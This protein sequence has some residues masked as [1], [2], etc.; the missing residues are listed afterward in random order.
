MNIDKLESD[1][2]SKNSLSKISRACRYY[3]FGKH[4]EPLKLLIKDLLDED[5]PNQI[6]CI[7]KFIEDHIHNSSYSSENQVYIHNDRNIKLMTVKEGIDSLILYVGLLKKRE[8]NL[9]KR[10]REK[11]ERRIQKKKEKKAIII[12]EKLKSFLLFQEIQIKF[13]VIIMFIKLI[14]LSKI[15]QNC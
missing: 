3:R 10:K 4:N 7:I 12:R 1:R 5:L 14:L 2:I 11:E 6:I 13:R 9:I 15:S 8:E